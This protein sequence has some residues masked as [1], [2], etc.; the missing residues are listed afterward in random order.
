MDF[1]LPKRK[2]CEELEGKTSPMLST[3]AELHGRG[4][5]HV[6]EAAEVERA[7]GEAGHL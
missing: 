1:A 6:S 2:Q 7:D 5:E 4:H 3:G